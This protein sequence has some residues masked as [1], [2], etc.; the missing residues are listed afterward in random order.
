[1]R[2]YA[3]ISSRIL[4]A[5]NPCHSH[6]I[7]PALALSS[8][9]SSSFPTHTPGRA[10]ACP[11]VL[12]LPTPPSASKIGRPVTREQVAAV[13]GVGVNRLKEVQP[14]QM[15]LFTQVDLARNTFA[16][17][18]QGVTASTRDLRTIGVD[19]EMARKGKGSDA[20]S[21]TPPP[22]KGA[23][24]RF[25]SHEWTSVEE[26]VQF[27]EEVMYPLRCYHAVYAVHQLNSYHMKDVQKRGLTA[28]KQEVLD[29]NKIQLEKELDGMAKSQALIANGVKESLTTDICNDIVNILRIVGE[30]YEHAHAMA[31]KVL[32]DMNTM[33]IP[34][35]EVTRELIKM[36][37]FHDGPFDNSSLLFEIIEYP[38]RGEIILETEKK[39]ENTNLEARSTEV[40]N[41]IAQRHQTELDDGKLLRSEETHPNLQRSPE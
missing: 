15:I 21:S 34:Y 23:K 29:E 10:I 30:K 38:E 19:L 17:L 27:Y 7:A 6:R 25:E 33:N 31:V 37:S 9:I 32:E 4:Y 3:A 24:E 14:P 11:A 41:I 12:R 36:V 2:R 1:M 13:Y 8:C 22:V 5:A 35:N 18:I 16:T 40:L 20:S 28:F 26:L 39:E